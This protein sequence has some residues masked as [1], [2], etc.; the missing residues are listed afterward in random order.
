MFIISKVN[1]LYHFL[2]ALEY[3]LVFRF[4]SEPHVTQETVLA[5][6]P[7][8]E[9]TRRFSTGVTRE[10]SLREAGKENAGT[11]RNRKTFRNIASYF[12]YFC[13]RKST[14]RREPLKEG[15]R[16]GVK[17]KGTGKFKTP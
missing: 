5:L 17:V 10:G 4:Q 7:G 9:E 16:P 6:T 14:K 3:D 15:C 12:I 1:I 8:R 2:E 11:G 13:N